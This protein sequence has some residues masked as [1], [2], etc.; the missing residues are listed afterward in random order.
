MAETRTWL[1]TPTGQTPIDD[2]TSAEHWVRGPGIPTEPRP[3]SRFRGAWTLAIVYAV[4]IGLTFL[5][6]PSVIDT[7]DPTFGGDAERLDATDENP[8]FERPNSN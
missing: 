4:A 8:T 7:Q 5:I 1:T 2:D 3:P 6:V